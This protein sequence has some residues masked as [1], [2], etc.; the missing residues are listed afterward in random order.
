MNIYKMNHLITIKWANNGFIF[1][2][3]PSDLG[4]NC[5]QNWLLV[6]SQ[7][8]PPHSVSDLALLFLQRRIYATPAVKGLS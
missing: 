8:R 7:I 1:V 5:L 3:E 4:L 6:Q 2:E